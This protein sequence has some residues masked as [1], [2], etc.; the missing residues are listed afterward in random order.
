MIISQPTPEPNESIELLYTPGCLAWKQAETNL[1]QALEQAG[2]NDVPFQVVAIE[3]MEQARAYNFFASPTIHINGIDIEPHSRH[4][5]RRGLGTGR[6]Y[7]T[8]GQTLAVP[9]IELILA[10]LKELY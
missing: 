4:V 7:F 9:P 1:K 10:A 8:Q 3:T 6:P 2:L 5:S